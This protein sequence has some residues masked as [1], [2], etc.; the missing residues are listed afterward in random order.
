MKVACDTLGVMYYAETKAQRAN[1]KTLIMTSSQV[2]V[3]D[4]QIGGR[5]FSWWPDSHLS[6]SL[7]GDNKVC[8][9]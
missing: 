2:I 1:L 8:Q 4:G 7:W 9:M 6:V 3:C 5:V